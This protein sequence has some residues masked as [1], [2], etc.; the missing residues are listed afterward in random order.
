MVLLGP[1]MSAVFVQIVFGPFARLR[2][3]TDR[4]TAIA[5]ID[6]SR[7]AYDTNW[8]I[9]SADAAMKSKKHFNTK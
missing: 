6:R 9:R 8:I 5:K 3:T 1:I 7:E 2:R 4:A